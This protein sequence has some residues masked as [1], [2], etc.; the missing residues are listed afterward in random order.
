MWHGHSL[1][2]GVNL[3]DPD[4]TDMWYNDKTSTASNRIIDIDF[5][6]L[7]TC[8]FIFRLSAFSFSDL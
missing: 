5:P 1:A 4:M 7:L 6:T 2:G 8:F 3:E